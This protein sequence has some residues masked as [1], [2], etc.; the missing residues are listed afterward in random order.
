MLGRWGRLEE[1][2][3][4]K[5]FPNSADL[6]ELPQAFLQFIT[7]KGMDLLSICSLDVFLKIIFLSLLLYLTT[8][9]KDVWQGSWGRFKSR[10]LHLHGVHL[11]Q[12]ICREVLA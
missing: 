7:M 10:M 3:L 5:N 8:T 4:L 12:L 11:R 1:I 2:Q 6:V 9:G